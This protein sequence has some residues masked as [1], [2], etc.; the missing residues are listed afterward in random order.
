[1]SREPERWSQYLRERDA[2]VKLAWD[3]LGEQFGSRQLQYGWFY[4]GDPLF[5]RARF[6]RSPVVAQYKGMV[7]RLMQNKG[8]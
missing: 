6:Y 4:A 3:M 1:M 2:G 5:T 7:D 8:L